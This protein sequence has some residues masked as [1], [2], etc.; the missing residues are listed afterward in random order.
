MATVFVPTADSQL[1]FLTCRILP[2]GGHCTETIEV[3]TSE[4]MR[5]AC[6]YQRRDNG[7]YKGEDEEEPHLLCSRYSAHVIDDQG[8]ASF[9]I[10]IRWN[11]NVEYVMYFFTRPLTVTAP[12]DFKQVSLELP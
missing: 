5:L 10:P 2:V 11:R 7:H 9:S 8:F 4:P 6:L 12:I 1:K 3:K